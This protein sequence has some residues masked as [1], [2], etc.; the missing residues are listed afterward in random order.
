[1]G[2]F[3]LGRVRELGITRAA[4]TAVGDLL[5]NTLSGFWVHL[6]ADVL[7]DEIM[8]AVDYRMPDG[9]SFEDLDELLRTLLGTGRAVGMSVTIFNPS[10]DGDG[11]IARGFAAAINAGLGGE[12]GTR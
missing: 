4:E 11:R 5:R 3:D 8:P 2:V 9:L 10:L 12:R 7:D 1:M 6:D